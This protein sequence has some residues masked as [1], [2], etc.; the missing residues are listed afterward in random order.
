MNVTTLGREER[1]TMRM[2]LKNNLG[3]AFVRKVV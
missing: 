3:G 2:D 1:K